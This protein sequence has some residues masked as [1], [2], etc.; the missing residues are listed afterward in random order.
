MTI[1]SYV[2]YTELTGFV[3]NQLPTGTAFAVSD[4]NSSEQI[5]IPSQVARMQNLLPGD[6][7]TVRAIPNKKEGGAKWFAVFASILPREVEA[8]PAA[9]EPE[10]AQIKLS[11]DWYASAKAALVKLGG[12]ATTAEI[13][14][15]CGCATQFISTYLRVLHDRGEVCRAGIRTSSKQSKD[16]LVYWGLTLDDLIPVGM[17]EVK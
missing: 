7:V 1:N 13:A 12:V 14:D 15:E 5:F 10:P 8:E 4:Q 9:V 6:R 11:V 3:L 2:A 16:S 17:G